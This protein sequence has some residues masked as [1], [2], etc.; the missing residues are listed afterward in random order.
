[1]PPHYITTTKDNWKWNTNEYIITPKKEGTNAR[2]LYKLINHGNEN[3][4]SFKRGTK[5]KI[6]KIKTGKRKLIYMVEL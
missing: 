3:Q 1:M 2:S 6:T 4:V 5:F